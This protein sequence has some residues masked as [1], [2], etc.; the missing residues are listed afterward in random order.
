M[1]NCEIRRIA[2][3]Y[4]NPADRPRTESEMEQL[5]QYQIAFE[6]G[7]PLESVIYNFD[8]RLEYYQPILLSMEACLKCHG[9]PGTHID[10]ATMEMIQLN[11]PEDLATGFKLNDIR[12][13]WKITFMK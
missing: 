1:N 12:G 7:K 2:Q 9:T 11:Y 8:D 4:R 3:K 6:E 5:S 10:D 13:A